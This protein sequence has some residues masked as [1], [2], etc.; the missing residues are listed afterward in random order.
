MT[1]EQGQSRRSIEERI[2]LALPPAVV[3]AALARLMRLP[4]GSALR[5]RVLKRAV[6]R[7]F[8]GPSRGD[9]ELLLLFYEP[10]VEIDVIGEWARALGLAERYRGHEGMLA[11]WSDYQQ[12]A[13]LR[14]EPEELIDLGDRIAL[15]VSLNVRGR[16]SG[17]PTA[18]PIG[19]IYYLSQRGLIARQTFYSDWEDVLAALG[20][21]P[22]PASAQRPKIGRQ[23]P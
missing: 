12:D 3:H 19:F 22:Q 17:A 18:Q 9:Y 6:A 13:D 15:R 8:A 7:G 11:I 23:V 4:P 14:V 1:R 10:D 16:A 21:R 2:A 20:Q 5:R